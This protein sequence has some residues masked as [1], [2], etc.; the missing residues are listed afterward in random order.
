MAT[1]TLKSRARRPVARPAGRLAPAALTFLVAEDSVG[2]S[3]ATI[4]D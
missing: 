1:A 2:D 4:L 3:C